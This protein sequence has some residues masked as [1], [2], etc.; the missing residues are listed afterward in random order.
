M[1]LAGMWRFMGMYEIAAFAEERARIREAGT[2]TAL[3]AASTPQSYHVAMQHDPEIPSED[4]DDTHVWIPGGTFQMGSERFYPEERPIHRVHVEDFWIAATPVTNRQFAVFV[5]ATGYRTVAERAP[6]PALYPGAPAANL[7][8]GSLVFFPSAGPVD[9]R[10]LANWWAWTP[11]ANWRQPRGP[12]SSLEYLEHHPVVH[13]ALE[14]AHAYCA[15]A[16]ADLPTE[17]EWEFAARGGHD[18]ATFV[19]GEDE[20]P[21]GQIMANT[22]QGQFP[23]QNTAEDGFILTS[24]VGSYPAN[25]YGLF[26]M[27]GNVWEWTSDWW[28]ASHPAAQERACCVP[29]NPRGG[30]RPASGNRRPTPRAIPRKVVKGGSHLC[31]PGY[32][33]RYRPAA[34]Q[35]QDIDTGMSHVGFRV[36][37]RPPLEPG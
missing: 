7:V 37:V 25:S 5:A 17:A 30:T 4:R 10:N 33:F 19:W 14:D 24:P 32:C 1:S 18:G 9:V 16:E 22:W 27:A 29:G 12:N 34:R 28:T 26:D 21:D 20:C 11:G 36:V 23:W 8:A 6:D 2:V 35:P 31:A 13:V 3:M 15:W